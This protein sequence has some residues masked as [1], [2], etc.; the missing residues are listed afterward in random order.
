MANTTPT[1]PSSTVGVKDI[2]AKLNAPPVRLRAFIRSLDA[3]LKGGR[4][5]R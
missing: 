5:A 1:T 3:D 2:A 4:G